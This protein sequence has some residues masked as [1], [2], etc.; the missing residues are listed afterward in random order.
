MDLFKERT[1]GIF[2][3]FDMTDK[4]TNKRKLEA[5]IRDFQII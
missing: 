4:D 5:G 2:K 1:K 3:V